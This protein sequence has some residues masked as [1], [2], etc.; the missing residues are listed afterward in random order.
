M[1]IKVLLV[2]DEKE[3]VELLGERMSS[4]GMEVSSTTSAMGPSKKG[5][6]PCGWAPWTLWR[7]RPTWTR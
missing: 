7:N 4:R 6:R 1:S 3:F 2:D 5:W